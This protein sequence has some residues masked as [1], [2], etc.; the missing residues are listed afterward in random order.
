MPSLWP[1][2]VSAWF[3][4]FTLLG[5]VS[6]DLPVHCVRHEVVGEWRFTLGRL[7]AHRTSC[8][9]QRPDVEEAQPGRHLVDDDFDAEGESRVM[10]TMK[11]PNIAATARDS[12]G[13]WTMIYDE[14]FELTVGGMNFFAFSNFTLQ[15]NASDPLHRYNQSHCGYTMVGWYQNLDRTKF[16]CYYAEKVEQEAASNMPARAPEPIAISTTAAPPAPKENVLSKIASTFEKPLDPSTQAKKV[17]K[18][19]QKINLL[20]LGWTAR[21]HSKWNGL[22]L[23]EMN[24]YAGLKRDGGSDQGR[25]DMLLQ[26]QVHSER[27][28][29]RHAG[30]SFLQRRATSE[31]SAT[32][33]HHK[34][35]PHNFDWS[36]ATGRNFLEEVMDQGDCGSCYATASMRMLTARHKI[37]ENNTEAVPW[38]INF[39]LFCSEYNQGCKGGYGILTAK[40]SRDVGLLPA[41]CMRYNTRGSCS[42]ECNLAELK[43][44]RYRAANHRYVGNWYGNSTIDAIKAELFENGPLVLGLEP[45]EDFMFYSDGIYKSVQHAEAKALLQPPVTEPKEWEKVDHAVLLVG[46]GEDHGQKYWRLQNSWGPDW[47][48]DGFFRIAMGVN[49]ASIESIAEAADVVEDEQQGQQVHAFFEGQ[50][51]LAKVTEKAASTTASSSKPAKQGESIAAKAKDIASVVVKD[52]ES[53]AKDVKAVAKDITAVAKELAVAKHS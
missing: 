34:Q 35:L 40:W 51:Q 45:S 13:T 3:A 19:K 31:D 26:K 29:G 18:V 5:P 32:R 48:E 33:G 53:V 36:N 41:T 49:E 6:A 9:H 20:Q 23:K 39:P 52:I 15:R 2:V 4:L 47:G 37:R 10:V 27:A 14:G 43:G 25:R 21:P 7:R 1:A 22:S 46:W 28:S 24:T 38:S 42:L 44:K 8:G 17:E 50:R 16:G 12:A 11:Q 30:R